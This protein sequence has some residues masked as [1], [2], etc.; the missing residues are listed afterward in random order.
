MT[1]SKSFYFEHDGVEYLAE[2]VL[3]CEEEYDGYLR[4]LLG[5]VEFFEA[6]TEDE[7]EAT[8]ELYDILE[9]KVESNYNSLKKLF[10]EYDK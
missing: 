2:T 7:V 10:T 4:I 3:T 8:E 1:A 5:S 9:E 6:E